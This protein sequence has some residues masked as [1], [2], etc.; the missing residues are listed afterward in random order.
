MRIISRIVWSAVASAIAVVTS[1][2]LAFFG[3]AT[4]SL[5]FGL[6]GV[7]LAILSTRERP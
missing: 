5:A 4:L 7:S 3:D 1:V 6:A 2:V